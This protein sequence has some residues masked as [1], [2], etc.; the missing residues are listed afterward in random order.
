MTQSDKQKGFS[1]RYTNKLDFLKGWYE[2]RTS[3]LSTFKLPGLTLE[4][5]EKEIE[6]LKEGSGGTSASGD[7][8]AAGQVAGNGPEEKTWNFL[9][10]QGLSAAAIAGVM[11]NL[12]QES[13]ID[14]KKLQYG[15]G[16]GRGICQWETHPPNGGRWDA[17]LKWAKGAGKDEWAIETQLEWMWKELT[18]ADI[19]RRMTNKGCSGGFEGFKKLTDY[20]EACRIFEEAFERAGKPNFENR[21]KYAQAYYDKWSKNPPSGDVS[22]AKGDAKKVIQEAT[23]WLSKPNVY[24]FGGGRTQADIAAGKF[25]CSSWVRYVFAQCGYEICAFGGNTDSILANK[26]L[27]SIKSSDLQPGDM[28]FWNTYKSYGH[29]GIYLGNNRAIGDNG[30]TGTGKVSYID[31]NNSYYKPRLEAQGRRVKWNA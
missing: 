26:D 10:G 18:T 14:P 27:I 31:M 20:K 1:D 21:Y 22:G 28:V 3:F 7:G 13:G 24:W 25:D 16:P 11:G 9:A 15:G 6:K 23:S 8:S 29:I 4:D 12:K 2:E 19:S 17:L 5:L 30:N